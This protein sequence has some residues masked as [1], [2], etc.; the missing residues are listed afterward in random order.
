MGLRLKGHSR[1]ETQLHLGDSWRELAGFAGEFHAG[2]RE[3]EQSEV[4]PEH[5]I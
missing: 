4:T 2:L 5:L 1:G 3:P